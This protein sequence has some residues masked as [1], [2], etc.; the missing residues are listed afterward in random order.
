[1]VLYTEENRQY[2]EHEHIRFQLKNAWNTTYRKQLDKGNVKRIITPFRAV[3][4][5]G[6]LLSRQNYSCGGSSQVAN[7]RPGLKGL[8]LG[9]IFSNCDGTGV[10][11]ASCNTKYVYDGSDYVTYLKQ[12]SMLKEKSLPKI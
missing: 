3:N 5:C 12:R 1:M 10:P 11:P 6:D 9:A 4:N 2:P 7:S 8:R